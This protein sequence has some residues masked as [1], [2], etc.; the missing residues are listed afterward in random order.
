MAP[1]MELS[2]VSVEECVGSES[3]RSRSVI[4]AANRTRKPAT[5][6]CTCARNMMLEA[7][8][9]L[10]NRSVEL[11]KF[12]FKGKMG[13]VSGVQQQN[14]IYVAGFVAKGVWRKGVRE[15]KERSFPVYM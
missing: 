15:T 14:E 12:R 2:Q 9:R 1:R 6:L 4:I 7:Q 11:C 8:E 5:R 13:R 3:N 10:R